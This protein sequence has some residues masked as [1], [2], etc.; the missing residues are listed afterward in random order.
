MA[1]L[2]GE[3]EEEEERPGRAGVLLERPTPGCLW[4]V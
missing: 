3:E 4:V 1:G 2:A